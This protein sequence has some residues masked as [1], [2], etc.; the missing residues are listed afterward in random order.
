MSRRV[1][2]LA[3]ELP[4]D[5]TVAAV[6]DE[7]DRVGHRKAL[8]MRL[9]EFLH[10]YRRSNGQPPERQMRIRGCRVPARA[11]VVEELVIEVNELLAQERERLRAMSALRVATDSG[12]GSS[13]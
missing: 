12:E 6:L 3:A 2:P 8:L 4:P 1:S 10:S 5:A 7:M 11:D 9:A 13:P